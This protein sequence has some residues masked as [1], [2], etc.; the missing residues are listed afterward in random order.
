MTKHLIVNADDLGMSPGVNRGILTSTTAMTNLPDAADGIR[1]AQQEA[2]EMGLGL[3][4]NFTHGRPLQPIDSLVT[5]DGCFSPLE[6]LIQ[7]TAH[8]NPDEMAAEVEAQFNRFVELAGTVP[9]HI[10]SHHHMAFFFPGSLRRALELAHEHNLPLRYPDAFVD[11]DRI[12]LYVNNALDETAADRLAQALAA[13]CTDYPDFRTSDYIERAFD[14]SINADELAA[15][16]AHL[17]DGVTEMLCH[18]GYAHEH[19]DVLNDQREV[20][21]KL[22]TDPAII[23]LVAEQEIELITF[24]ALIE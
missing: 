12:R 18:P 15:V 3:H 14:A 8:A 10:D 4:L 17:P 21:L 7:Q 5:E 13:V 1:Q 6:T 23:A 2:P 9:D 24:R 16:F 11:A 19:N 20:E 22:L